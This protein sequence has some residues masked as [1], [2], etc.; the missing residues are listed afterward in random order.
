MASEFPAVS[1]PIEEV[2][3]DI[4]TPATLPRR[5]RAVPP[6]DFERAVIA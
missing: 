5:E 1:E 2:P 3:Q 6:H 4:P